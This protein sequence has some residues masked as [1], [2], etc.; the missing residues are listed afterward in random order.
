MMVLCR[1][2][3][4]ALDGDLLVESDYL[5][6]TTASA[7]RQTIILASSMKKMRGTSSI[8]LRCKTDSSKRPDPR[9]QAWRRH[10]T[11]LKSMESLFTSKT[12]RILIGST[13]SPYRQQHCCL[14]LLQPVTPSVPSISSAFTSLS[15]VRQRD[16]TVIVRV[17]WF[18]TSSILPQRRYWYAPHRLL[19]SEFG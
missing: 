15:T 2:S 4:T 7:S 1:T 16:P 18:T 11:G 6:V 19:S 9:T 13:V 12:K 3:S 14:H 5:A 8:P 17:E 10:G